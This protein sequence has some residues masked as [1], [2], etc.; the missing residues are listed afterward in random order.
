VEIQDSKT[1]AAREPVA[2][3][4]SMA[5]MTSPALPAV[6]AAAAP[7]PK[8]LL[9]DHLDGGLRVGTLLALLRARGLSAP[10]ADEAGLAAWFDANAHA[11]SLEKYLEGFALT[12]AAMATPEAMRRVAFEAAEDARAGGALLAEF[13][14]A[15]L[16]F[17]PHGV[18]G[19]DSVEALLA[20]L[21]QSPLPS[22]LIVCAMRHESPE[23][24]LRAAELALR[25]QGRGVVGFDL[26]GAERGHPPGDH[27]AALA[28]V[29]EAGL[30]ITLHAGEADEAERVLEAGRLGAR[31]IGHGVRLVD[32]L[33]SSDPARRALVDEAKALGLHLEVCP[34]SNV[35]TGAAPSIAGHPITALWRAGVSLSYHTDNTLMSRITLQGE[36]DALLRETPLMRLDLLRMARAAAEASFLPEAPRRAA[37]AA[38][39][40]EIGAAN[41]HKV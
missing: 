29:R 6:P 41:G 24:T 10:A 11:G 14:I 15:P 32:A 35:H 9:H 1:H 27:A 33:T 8:V 12:V 3:L 30:P 18:G 19:D 39:D 5:A 26:A 16:L 22:G 23:R 37:M 17:E 28:R 7:L 34:T 25:W 31:R 36:A 38:I 40:A 13:R 4:D 21:A 2:T 20:G